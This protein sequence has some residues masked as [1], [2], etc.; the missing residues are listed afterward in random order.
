MATESN[1]PPLPNLKRQAGKS[2]EAGGQDDP[3]I[4]S[5]GSNLQSTR[6]AAGLEHISVIL[7]DLA[8]KH[9]LPFCT[10]TGE[11]AP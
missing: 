6:R 5:T 8:A 9:S 10:A 1:D 11:V 7:N 4:T 2:I 3:D